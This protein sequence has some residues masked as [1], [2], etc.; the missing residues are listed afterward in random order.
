MDE[1]IEILKEM[2]AENV[3]FEVAK[4]HGDDELTFT[5][6][7]RSIMVSGHGYNDGTGGLDVEVSDGVD[8]V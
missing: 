4:H 7:G 6:N 2:G 1:L 3:E 8:G 5:F